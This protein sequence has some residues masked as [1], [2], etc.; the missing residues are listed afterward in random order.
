MAVLEPQTQRVLGCNIVVLVQ[1]PPG[2][3]AP[4]WETQPE[5][6]MGFDRGD[7]AHLRDATATLGSVSSGIHP[8][9]FPLFF[10]PDMGITADK[11]VLRQ[12]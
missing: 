1:H 11:Q 4:T 12:L 10:L 5:P 7:P 6:H 2:G 8:A 3:T 9:F